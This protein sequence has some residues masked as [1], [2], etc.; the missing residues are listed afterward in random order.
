M[1][2]STQGNVLVDKL[3]NSFPGGGKCV[4]RLISKKE[5]KEKLPAGGV[6]KKMK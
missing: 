5:D 2:Q 6:G 1:M 4:S 3:I